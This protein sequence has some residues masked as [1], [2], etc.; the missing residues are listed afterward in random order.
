MYIARIDSAPEYAAPGHSGM[1]MRRL[2][3]REAGPADTMWLALSTIE[4]G[5]GVSLSASAAEKFYVVLDGQVEI[6]NGSD[7]YRLGVHDSCRIAP[8]EPRMI[9]NPGPAVASLLL[10]MAG[11]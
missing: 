9:H 4:P 5:G 3:G 7:T 1:T 6:S 11:P 2:Q 8:N 10:S